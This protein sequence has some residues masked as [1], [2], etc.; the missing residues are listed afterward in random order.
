M[1]DCFYR[2][3]PHILYEDI[4]YNS[5]LIDS[6]DAWLCGDLHLE[7]LGSYEADNRLTY[8]GVNDFDECLLGSL[9]LIFPEC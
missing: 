3:I 4:P 7:N 9:L 6:P 8:F 2:A 1:R 5:F